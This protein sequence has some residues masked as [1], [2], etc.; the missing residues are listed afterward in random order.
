[1]ETKRC[2][3]CGETKEMDDFIKESGC[4]LGRSNVC[5]PCK[6]KRVNLWRKN[7]KD[8]CR[9]Y[10]KKAKARNPA[11]HLER[12]EYT[13]KWHDKHPEYMNNYMKKGIQN[14]CNRYISYRLKRIGIHIVTEELIELKREQL[15]LFRNLK[16]LK[17]VYYES[18]HSNPKRIESTDAKDF[19]GKIHS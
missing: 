16:Q 18:N 9:I 10:W 1:M 8:K 17:E 6:N 11:R 4:V 15:M 2:S 5:K 7:N 12:I 13:K 19:Q 14:L 3:K